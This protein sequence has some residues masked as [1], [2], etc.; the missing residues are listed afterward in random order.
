MLRQQKKKEMANI[1][2]QAAFQQFAETDSKGEHLFGWFKRTVFEGSH[3]N[4]PKFRE[5]AFLTSKG[6]EEAGMFPNYLEPP[7][8]NPQS[9]RSTLILSHPHMS[10][11]GATSVTAFVRA[12]SGKST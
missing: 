7:V 4:L 2:E 5:P 12:S 10:L 6:T 9:A 8:F 11:E 1:I 3:V